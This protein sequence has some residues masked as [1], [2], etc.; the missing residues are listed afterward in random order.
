LKYV[1]IIY[2][3]IFLILS[4]TLLPT[5]LRASDNRLPAMGNLQLAVPDSDNQLN[6][7]DFGQNP[8]GLQADQAYRWMRI[9]LNA[10][11]HWGPYRRLYD[12]GDEQNYSLIFEGVK[13][14]NSKETFWGAVTYLGD[15]PHGVYRSLEKHAYEKNF[16]LTDTTTGNYWYNGPIIQ[17]IYSRKLPL[18]FSLGAA[19][20]YKVQLG[21]KDVYTKV[22]SI[23][24]EIFP[25]IAL[26]WG[27]QTGQER[28]SKRPRLSENRC[29]ERIGLNYGAGF[30][31]YPYDNKTRLTAVKEMQDAV[32]YRQ[33]G[34]LTRFREVRGK[35]IRDYRTKGV[36]IGGQVFLALSRAIHL[37]LSHRYR[38]LG[39]TTTDNLFVKRGY[40]QQIRNTTLGRMVFRERGWQISA[41]ASREAF[42]D[43][44]KT[45]EY[46]CLY[47]EES[48]QRV[49]AGI[50]IG[51]DRTGLPLTMGIEFYRGRFQRTYRD[52]LSHQLIENKQPEWELRAGLEI[53][54]FSDAW[55]LRLGGNWSERVPD[56]LYLYERE[57]LWKLTTGLSWQGSGFRISLLGTFRSRIPDGPSIEISQ[58]P[59][60]LSPYMPT[61]RRQRFT[62]QIIL[63]LFEK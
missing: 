52:Y 40:E 11:N 35:F 47:G 57:K 25:G 31:V 43:W 42:D 20:N 2:L 26:S 24:R 14:L 38:A 49:T 16:I 41:Q 39:T 1:K 15:Y 30:F 27:V 10:Q 34:L 18:N 55:Q 28:F 36:L 53:P 63:Q 62:F 22:E 13:A 5:N 48:R 17:A 45:I 7:Y 12:P 56:L 21:L 19:F 6:F 4:G 8:A 60:E 58:P 9:Y 33:I 3:L 44:S 54:V 61:G 32:V 37:G 59:F 23:Q 29:S 51:T 50:G 46:G